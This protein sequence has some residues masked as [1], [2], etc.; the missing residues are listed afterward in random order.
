MKVSISDET[1]RELIRDAIISEIK[2]GLKHLLVSM[3]VDFFTD[4]HMLRIGREWVLRA[5]ERAKRV[6]NDE[7]RLC[8]VKVNLDQP[9]QVEDGLCDLLSSANPLSLDGYD[10]YIRLVDL[11]CREISIELGNSNE[12]TG[13]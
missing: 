8:K 10:V 9:S 12:A 3:A 2:A 1:R 7:M 4:E 11:F 6:S 13:M 5:F